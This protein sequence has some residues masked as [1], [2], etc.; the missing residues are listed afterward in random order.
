MDM[1]HNTHQMVQLTKAEGE[2]HTVA[3]GTAA[4]QWRRDRCWFHRMDGQHEQWCLQ[5]LCTHSTGEKHRLASAGICAG[6][7]FLILVTLFRH[8]LKSKLTTEEY[9]FW[10]LCT[11]CV[12]SHGDPVFS[13]QSCI[14]ISLIYCGPLQ[15]DFR[16]EATV[17]PGSLAWTIFNHFFKVGFFFF[18]K[19]DSLQIQLFKA[20]WSTV[21]L[22]LILQFHLCITN[23]SIIKAK[24]MRRM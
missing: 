19:V 8:F 1:A 4:C 23:Y 7:V 18:T 17:N 3:A 21:Y 12:H 24:E 14:S 16:M 10:L 9:W 5:S 11:W 15:R 22:I 13:S 2:S 20:E 6:S